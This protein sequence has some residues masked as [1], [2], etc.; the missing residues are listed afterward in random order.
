MS[1]VKQV[2][3]ALKDIVIWE[4]EPIS[5]PQLDRALAGIFVEDPILFYDVELLLIEKLGSVT[6]TRKFMVGI[7]DELDAVVDAL[8]EI[9]NKLRGWSVN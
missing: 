7:A 6:F 2:I 5:V 9:S 3:E 4:P 8:L 1:T